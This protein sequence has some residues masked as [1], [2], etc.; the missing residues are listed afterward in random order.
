MFNTFL[1]F[2]ILHFLLYPASNAYNSYYDKDEKSIGGLQNPP[3]VSSQLYWVAILM[4]ALAVI[5][6]LI[7]S[8]E[9]ALMLLVYGLVSKAYSHPAIRLKKMPIVGWLTIGTFQGFFTFLMSIAG[10]SGGDINY[11]WQESFTVPAALSS[12][13]LL[14][15]Y[16]MTQVYQHEEDSERGDVTIS[17]KLGILGTF[18]FTLV[19]FTFASAGFVWYY[20]TF[21]DNNLAYYFLAAMLPVVAFFNWWYFQ[22]RKNR[23][24]ADFKNTMRLNL[25]SALALN[26]FFLAVRFLS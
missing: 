19:M 12:A 17:L 24:K 5:L 9:F 23:A 1:T 3:P 15:S 14:G 2:F 20:F 26:T 22:V 16:P 7:V 6:G 13:M 10:L 11:L 8:I 25:L 18:H 4:D 21:Y